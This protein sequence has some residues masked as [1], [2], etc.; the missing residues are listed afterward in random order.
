[1][2][3]ST[4]SNTAQGNST[5]GTRYSS[6]RLV[7]LLAELSQQSSTAPRSDIA[8]GLG[9]MIDLSESIVISDTLA[10]LGKMSAAPVSTVGVEPMERLQLGHA[11]MVKSVM[12]SVARDSTS[13]KITLGM[14]LDDQ[15][16]DEARSQMEGPVDFQPY[17]KLYAALQRDLE[18][19]ARKIQADIRSVLAA[20]SADGARL[21]A[22]DAALAD[23][24]A[25]HS[26][27]MF[28]KIPVLLAN[29]FN[30]IASQKD[31]PA[32][33]VQEQL[34]KLLQTILLAEIEARLMPAVGLI[35]AL[36]EELE[37]NVDK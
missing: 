13:A 10:G 11:A 32:L 9:S 4:S 1:M 22:L 3:Q 28:A 36:E 12:G 35:E 2:T 30:A 24:V 21:A 23:P 7:G 27:A 8:Q 34:S 37:P 29:R 6:S 19:K 20:R 15:Q 26:R 14:F 33:D 31:T 17:L 18:F 25:K 5:T 16:Q